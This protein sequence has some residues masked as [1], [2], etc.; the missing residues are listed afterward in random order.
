MREFAYERPTSLDAAVAA[1]G[2]G[3]EAALIAGGHTLLP[4][5]KSRLRQPDTLV[6]LAGVP[7]LT[8]IAREGDTLWIGAM[9]THAVVA[10]DPVVAAAISGL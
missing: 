9:T 6:D 8:G 2:G 4:A 3:G 7:G 5:M 1:F 10:A